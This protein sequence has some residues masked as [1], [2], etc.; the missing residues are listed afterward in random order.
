MDQRAQRTWVNL[1][2]FV[3]SAIMGVLAA[4]LAARLSVA[5]DLEAKV[6]ALSWIVRGVGFAV[7]GGLFVGLARHKE[8]NQFMAEVV[9]ELS[10]VIWPS[11][12]EVTRS[13]T[14]VLV[15]V[16]ISGVLLGLLDFLSGKLIQLFL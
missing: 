12:S 9:T 5:F 3:V 2:F 15:M 13:T 11:Q 7:G 1:S 10:S 14:I 6:K 4:T 16:V 8:A